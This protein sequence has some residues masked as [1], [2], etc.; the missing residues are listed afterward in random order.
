VA[1]IPMI[2]ELAV[3]N[4]WTIERHNRGSAS[5]FKAI[6]YDAEGYQTAGSDEFTYKRDAI[7]FA[8]RT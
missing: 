3:V 7:A 2:E 6:K 4:G 5:T 1:R 8:E